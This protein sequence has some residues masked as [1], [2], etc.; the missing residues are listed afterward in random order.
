MSGPAASREVDERS[1]GGGRRRGC[2]GAVMEAEG[3]RARPSPRPGL[4]F[5]RGGSMDGSDKE[6]SIEPSASSTSE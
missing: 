4:D 2:R 3:G 1:R 5:S 6:A